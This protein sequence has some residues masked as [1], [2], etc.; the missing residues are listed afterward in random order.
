MPSLVVFTHTRQ[1]DIKSVNCIY[2][3][4]IRYIFLTVSIYPNDW[5]ISLFGEHN[6]W[7]S[8]S[9]SS[10]SSR[11][12]RQGITPCWKFIYNS[13]KTQSPYLCGTRYQT[14]YCD[15]DTSYVTVLPRRHVF[16]VERFSSIV[17]KYHWRILTA[18][19]RWGIGAKCQR[20]RNPSGRHIALIRRRIE[21]GPVRSKI[22]R[23][24]GMNDRPRSPTEIRWP[25]GKSHKWRFFFPH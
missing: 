11:V 4:I 5:S 25:F 21:H 9:S 12:R 19:S 24:N 15:D 14:M 8:S 23:D 7:G 16:V 3:Y 22:R 13:L 2:R 10:S 17:T 6:I 1:T 18:T 20:D